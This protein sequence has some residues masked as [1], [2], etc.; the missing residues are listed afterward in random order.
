MRK[1]HRVNDDAVLDRQRIQAW[2]A[3]AVDLG[4]DVVAPF[5]LSVNGR[6]LRCFA[7]VKGFGRSNGILLV[8]AESEQWK[9]G[10]DRPIFDLGYGVIHVWGETYAEYD[11]SSF[12]DALNDLGWKGDPDAAPDWY[13]GE[14]PTIGHR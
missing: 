6:E 8:G 1:N 14:S 7:L 12:I 5:A 11:R 4:I 2:R 13:T 10:G 3:A 9:E